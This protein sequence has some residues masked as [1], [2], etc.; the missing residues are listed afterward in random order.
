MVNA[1][2]ARFLYAAA[3]S[4]ML[5]CMT[6]SPWLVARVHAIEGIPDDYSFDSPYFSHNTVG[7]AYDKVG[8]LD[9]AIKAFKAAIK[10][11]I[12]PATS[13]VN[14]GVGLMRK[15]SDS[16]AEAEEAILKSLEIDPTFELAHENMDDL[17]RLMKSVQMESSA[18][19]DSRY[20]SKAAAAKA[21]DDDVWDD[22]EDDDESFFNSAM[23]DG[24]ASD[25]NGGGGG[26]DD[27][28]EWDDVEDD[29]ESFDIAFESKGGDHDE[30]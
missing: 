25:T 29:S 10:F 12:A 20:P 21:K 30:L 19:S 15:G 22:E 7:I 24:G 1:A 5:V 16:Y 2:G 18:G 13:W 26:D 4:A 28:E 23:D 11:G 9:N 6:T 14:L 3:V 27:E 8:Q 17:K